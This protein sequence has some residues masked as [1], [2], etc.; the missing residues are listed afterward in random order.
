MR[1]RRMIYLFSGH[2]RKGDLEW[3]MLR[4][5]GLI[6]IKLWMECLDLGYGDKYDLSSRKVVEH[7]K[8]EAARCFKRA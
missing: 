7:Y 3:F 4:K 2:R 8:E 1:H 6:G 5:C